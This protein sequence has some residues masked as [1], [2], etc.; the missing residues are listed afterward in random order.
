VTVR[1]AEG[2]SG[3]VFVRGLDVEKPQ[4]IVMRGGTPLSG[5]VSITGSKN[6]A[7]ALMAAS[8]LASEPV[9]LRNVPRIGDIHTMVELL[10]DL[11]ASTQFVED[12]AVRIDPTS[13]L[14]LE[15]PYE[16]VRKMRASF[17]VLGPL[18]ARFGFA[19]VPVP[20]GCDIGTRPVN[21]HVE[22]LRKL[23]ANLHSEHGV[24]TAE[25]RKL[26]GASIYMDFPSAGAT[27][28]LMTA[29]CLAH[30]VTIIEN[31][32]TEPEVVNLAAFL[33]SLGARVEGAGTAT[34]TVTGVEQLA[35]GEYDIIPDRMEAGTYAVAAAITQGEVFIESAVVE[36]M[37]PVVSKLQEAGVE[38]EATDAGLLVRG[39][40]RPKPVDIKTNP[41]PAFPTDMQQPF[42]ALL[43]IADGTSMITENVYESRFRYVN[44]LNRM[45]AD[46]RVS[47][48]TAVITG[49]ERLTGC[50]V[51]AT[52]LR[53][54]AALVCAGL[55]AE[56]TT[57]LTG[58]E[59][60][61]R[62]YEDMPRKLRGLG[63]SI[64][65]TE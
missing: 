13:I 57:E 28:H 44:E 54:A 3:R 38:V 19:R 41:H 20:G 50:P 7:L 42:A 62:G 52:D 51:A 27:Q 60:L 23:G 63:A 65:V 8:I 30:G 39:P 48:R 4:K 33:N 12:T 56:G 34:I 35:G 24:Y 37:R 16:L 59:H 29:A 36:H 5:T 25:A 64:C 31:C 11:G 6:A 58:V 46:I 14:T 45:G 40:S 26:E 32:A 15:A 21:F 55:A 49:V 17:N 43:S 47:A 10:N 22:G 2:S 61:E 9:T 18:V 1:R 53:A